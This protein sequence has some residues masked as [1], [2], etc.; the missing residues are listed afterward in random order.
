MAKVRVPVYGAP[1][2]SVLID[3]DIGA[4][5]AALQARVAALEPSS[6]GGG[7]GGS[8][9]HHALSDLQDGDDHP[10]YTMWQ[11]A[12]RITAPWS[13]VRPI[14]GGSGSAALPEFAFFEDPT[15]GVFLHGTGGLGLAAGGDL[16]LS[17]DALESRFFT[18]LA[19]GGTTETPFFFSLDGELLLYGDPG[20][21]GQVLSAG[22][23]TTGNQVAWI[24]AVLDIE[25]GDG[26]NVLDTDAQHPRIDVDQA[27]AF[28]WSGLHTF[29]RT[30]PPA[31]DAKT[32]LLGNGP[33]NANPL[34]GDPAHL[35]DLVNDASAL[36]VFRISTYGDP[37]TLAGQNNWHWMRARGSAAAPVTLESGD[38]FL[39]LGCR[40][41][42][43]TV[44]TQSAMAMIVSATQAWTATAHGIQIAFEVTPNNTVSRIAAF[45]IGQ[46]GALAQSGPAIQMLSLDSTNADGGYVMWNRSGV[47]KH[48][49]GSSSQLFFGPAAIDEMG[50]YSVNGIY[51]WG[52][53]DGHVSLR[54]GAAGELCII[55]G[56]TEPATLANFAQFYVDVADGS[57]KIKYGDGTV[58]TFVTV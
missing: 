3:P 42:D 33:W 31:I 8:L 25:A 15:S 21:P 7:S 54:L 35:V 39:S 52:L 40:G 41:Y 37:A 27:F 28:E 18:D 20:A 45:T 44:V 48:Y 2:K 4:A 1:I 51:N 22:A 46:N 9:S 53:A 36:Q 38:I 17:L 24:D 5:V 57:V 47:T 50:F 58:K 55:D 49:I 6:S 43:G 13:F 29:E 30:T 19:I 10:Q 14:L 12:E 56:I 34:S 11:A 23:P 16:K 32:A 26:I